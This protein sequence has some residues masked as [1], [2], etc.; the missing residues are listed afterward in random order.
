MSRII[1]T[2]MDDNSLSVIEVMKK[3]KIIEFYCHNADTSLGKSD[4]ILCSKVFIKIDNGRLISCEPEEKDYGPPYYEEF[5]L[6]LTNGW[7]VVTQPYKNHLKFEAERI[8]E[9]EKYPLKHELRLL[10][11]IEHTSINPITSKHFSTNDTLFET[12]DLLIFES[13]NISILIGCDVTP[14]WLFISNEKDV[15]DKRIRDY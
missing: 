5:Y 8:F 14:L 4:G 3:S 10:A 2:R 9:F 13:D 11:R 12:D 7:N 6:S 1:K 15:I